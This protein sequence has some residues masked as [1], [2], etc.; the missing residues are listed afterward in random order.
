MAVNFN[1]KSVFTADTND[2][3]KGA[4]EAKQAV[5]DFDDATTAALDEITGLFGTSMGQISKTLSTVRGGFMALAGGI[6]ATTK[7][8]S[9]ATKAMNI[10]KVA[11]AATGVGALVVALGSLVAY[12]TKTQVGADKLAVVMGQ[13]KQVLL[14]IS[15]TAIAVGRSMI[16]GFSKA[17]NFFESRWKL[18]KSRAGI[19]EV[20]D[21]EEKADKNVFQRRKELTLRQ[22]KLERDQ[23]QWT[24]DKAKLQ[25][26]IEQQREIAADKANRTAA[27][28]L[29]ANIKA[30]ELTAQL[31][32]QEKQFAQ[33]RLDIQI[34]ENSL[35]ESMNQDLLAQADLEAELINLEGQRASRT[36]ELLAQQAEITNQVK[37]E[38]EEREKMEA[39]QARKAQ[40]LTLE[41][42]DSSALLK[43]EVT[44]PSVTPIVDNTK[45]KEGVEEAEG[46]VVN[47][48][49]IAADFSN[50][51]SDAF[52][53]M[54]E[55]LVS[56]NVNMS[57]I[58]NTLLLFLAENLKA[59]GKALIA[60]GTAM[61]A[62]KKA[63]ENPWV[64]I[65]AG[66]ALVAAGA[67]LS[68]LIKK[69]SSGGGSSPSASYAAATVG[70]GGTLDLTSQTPLVPQTQE[71]RVTGTIKAS[72]RDLAVV[73]ENE[74]KRKNYTT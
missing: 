60:Y 62:F 50:T 46:Y 27:E 16:N 5:K 52:A 24:V 39:L 74:Q 40:D 65:A 64:A 59:I 14:V 12:F 42:I 15:D 6:D 1:L 33:E 48:G 44:S 10:F 18:F 54:I 28:R 58:F 26:K 68:G 20:A 67:V 57:D 8:T 13:L 32:A 36:K 25:T 3:K 53:S 49:E 73:I 31:Y 35:S 29:A 45:L 4:A 43:Q 47:F 70:S 66:A 72:G 38:R 17:F 2:L 34:E 9:L 55:G 23:A 56:G 37:L 71:V 51:L 41:K 61:E 69:A 19:K 22:Q 7:S 11:L 63:F 21:E 30:Q